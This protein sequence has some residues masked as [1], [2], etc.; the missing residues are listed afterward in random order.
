MILPPAPQACSDPLLDSLAGQDETLLDLPPTRG[1]RHESIRWDVV[2]AEYCYEGDLAP[3][4][5]ETPTLSTDIGGETC[6][7]ISDLW[8]YE[9]DYQELHPFQHRIRPVWC[10]EDRTQW[11]CS[12]FHVTAASRKLRT[13]LGTVRRVALDDV[14]WPL[15]VKRRD[16][17]GLAAGQR[18]DI[19]IR[20]LLDECGIHIYDIDLTTAIVAAPGVAWPIC[21]PRGQIVRALAAMAG[22]N[23][24]VAMNNG[25]VRGQLSAPLDDAVPTIS[26]PLSS[27]RIVADSIDYQE[28][29]F[30]APNSYVVVSGNG[31]IP[32][33][34]AAL[35]PADRP[36]SAESRGL[37][38]PEEIQMNGLDG[39]SAA[40][41]ALRAAAGQRLSDFEG[42]E[43]DSVPDP[44][45]GVFDLIEFGD[46]LYREVSHSLPLRHGSDHHHVLNRAYTLVEDTQ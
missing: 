8:I 29:Y 25:L 43:F 40:A 22:M 21:T 38:V 44:R 6:R 5:D 14:T 15:T 26:Y 20:L 18:I 2:D 28:N 31:Q 34:A 35:V 41:V 12:V 3:N 36:H 27:S 9:S 1:V 42:L 32:V 17:F 39:N 7:T 37:E 24:P 16:A 10:L 46:T 45:H 23:R 13:S 11:P 19:A 4:K 33:S 30:T